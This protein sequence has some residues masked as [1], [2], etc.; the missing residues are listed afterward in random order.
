MSHRIG[1]RSNWRERAAAGHGAQPP[2]PGTSENQA[3]MLPELGEPTNAASPPP[4][5]P[6]SPPAAPPTQPPAGT[7]GNGPGAASSLS[8]GAHK[9]L[10]F[11]FVFPFT[12]L[13]VGV[14]LAVALDRLGWTKLFADLGLLGGDTGL[15]SLGAVALLACALLGLVV[16]IGYAVHD[17][18]L[19]KAIFNVAAA[20]LPTLGVVLW[21][22]A[23]RAQAPA[24][25]LAE[26]Q[27]ESV[28]V[29][30][31]AEPAGEVQPPAT[32]V[33]EP[34]IP[35]PDGSDAEHLGERRNVA[36]AAPGQQIK[37]PVLVKNEGEAWWRNR[38]LCRERGE[39]DS[40][41][42]RSAEQCI[43]LRTVPPGESIEVTLEVVAPLLPD[44]YVAR[45]K[46]VS[47]DGEIIFPDVDPITLHVIVR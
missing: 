31:P 42:V 24:T 28:Q 33:A 18:P 2:V 36:V 37:H 32:D 35:S 34:T 23:A 27:S 1:G 29:G 6:T 8:F 20:V 3:G 14:V 9:K 12:G 26:A 7:P 45:W 30:R 40:P 41:A 21:I 17:N 43:Q 13:T 46:M 39:Q 44:Q 16:G 22:V 19:A 38:F 15:P 4:S 47:G 25:A 11:L 5:P 10:I